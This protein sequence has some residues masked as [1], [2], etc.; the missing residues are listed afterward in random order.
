MDCD[1]ECFW[2]K[3]EF[4]VDID[5][6]FDQECPRSIFEF[7][8]NLAK[9]LWVNHVTCFLISHPIIHRLGILAYSLWISEV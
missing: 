9:I 6:P 5:N 7:S 3:S 1:V 2:S 4:S 8:L